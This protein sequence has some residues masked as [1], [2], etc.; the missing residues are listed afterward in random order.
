MQE[1]G[2]YIWRPILV[3]QCNIL[4]AQCK[5]IKLCNNWCLLNSCTCFNTEIKGIVNIWKSKI[6]G[7]NSHNTQTSSTTWDRYCSC[8][9]SNTTSS[10]TP[11]PIL[12]WCFSS[13]PP[14][15]PS[16][17]LSPPRISREL[18]CWFWLLPADHIWPG[19]Q[20][21][22]WTLLQA[23]LYPNGSA[24]SYWCCPT[25]MQLPASV[26]R[27]QSDSGKWTGVWGSVAVLC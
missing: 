13:S 12:S 18:V 5:N 2:M 10:C 15:P 26:T 8:C 24:S 25:P 21:P 6:N 4:W 27:L 7:E 20:L 1:Q 9:V 23:A 14:P 16:P 19:S 22:S 3:V 11:P 17:S